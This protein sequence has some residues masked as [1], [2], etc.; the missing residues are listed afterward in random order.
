MK[1]TAKEYSEIL[2]A[3]LASEIQDIYNNPKYGENEYLQGQVVG[4]YTALNK[5][6]T[7]QFLI[8]D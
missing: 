6:D 4:L 5:I 3:I 8:E 1:K 7:S 2:K